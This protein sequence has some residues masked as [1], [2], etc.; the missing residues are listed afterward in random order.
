MT[1]P[2]LEEWL[3]DRPQI[4]KDLAR[5]HPPDGEYLLASDPNGDS[6][7]IHSYFEDG[8]MKTIRYARLADGSVQPLWSVFGMRPEDLVRV[9]KPPEEQ[10]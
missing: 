8:T 6:Y 2:T 7:Q 9:D 4:I 1:D 5:S 3:A 10:P